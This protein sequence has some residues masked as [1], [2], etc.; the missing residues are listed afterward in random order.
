MTTATRFPRRFQ[1]LE[2][3]RCGWLEGVVKPTLVADSLMADTDLS[4]AVLGS[5]GL[6]SLWTPPRR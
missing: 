2:T 3:V 6:L 5:T 1:V 4:V